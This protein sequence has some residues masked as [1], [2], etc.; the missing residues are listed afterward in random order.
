MKKYYLKIVN[1]VAEEETSL[2]IYREKVL[3]SKIIVDKNIVQICLNETIENYIQIENK[4]LYK[5]CFKIIKNPS[6]YF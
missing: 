6:R 3:E 4:Q 1:L 2:H 5:N